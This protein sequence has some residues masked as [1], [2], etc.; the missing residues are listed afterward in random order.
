MSLSNQYF[1][2]ASH[3]LDLLV[4]PFL[5]FIKIESESMF[6]SCVAHLIPP[7]S[8]SLRFI[9][10]SLF[11]VV[12][13]FLCVILLCINIPQ[14]GPLATSQAP[15]HLFSPGGSPGHQSEIWGPCYDTSSQPL[16]TTTLLASTAKMNENLGTLLFGLKTRESDTTRLRTE[17]I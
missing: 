6:S 12:V 17:V 11:V 13:H 14:F 16:N 2:K 15:L 7:H 5:S 4:C 1:S 10:V 8:M 3:Y 9:H